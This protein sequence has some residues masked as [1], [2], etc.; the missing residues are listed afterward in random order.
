[1]REDQEETR[2]EKL[3]R[4]LAKN[5]TRLA[6]DLLIKRYQQEL[7]YPLAATQFVDLEVSHSIKKEVYQKIRTL[8]DQNISASQPIFMPLH[9]LEKQAKV[10]SDVWVLFYYLDTLETE[11]IR[12]QFRDFWNI[13]HYIENNPRTDIILV[14][15]RLAFGICVELEEYNHL[16]MSWG[17]TDSPG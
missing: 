6:R 11:G 17:F 2:K 5:K 3:A 12:I 15:E 9:H 13:L 7:R 4:L 10:L 16:L 8:P 1:M 14:E